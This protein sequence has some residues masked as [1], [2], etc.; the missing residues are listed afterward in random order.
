MESTSFLINPMGLSARFKA[1]AFQA[2]YQDLE[3]KAAYQSDNLPLYLKDLKNYLPGFLENRSLMCD[4]LKVLVLLRFEN[5]WTQSPVDKKNAVL[6]AQPFIVKSIY[7]L[8]HK[9]N[10]LVDQ[11]TRANDEQLVQTTS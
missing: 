8:P 6:A 1:S 10:V 9:R 3:I 2:D 5:K 7:E 11:L 4:R